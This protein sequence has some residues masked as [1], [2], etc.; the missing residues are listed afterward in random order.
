M[1]HKYIFVA[2]KPGMSEPDFFRYWKEVHAER[3]GKK[4]KQARGYVIDSRIPFG[5]EP[6]EPLFSGAAEVWLDSEADAMEFIQSREY[7]D[8]SRL[9][10]PNFLA[11]W[12]MTVVDTEPHQIVGTPPERDAGWVKLLVLGKRNWSLSVDEFRRQ[13]LDV[14]APLVAALPG[15]KSYPVGLVPDSW[16]GVGEPLLDSVSQLYFEDT[17]ALQQALASPQFRE[18]VQPSVAR[19][20]ESKHVHTL[21]TDEYW[22]TPPP[23]RPIGPLSPNPG[24]TPANGVDPLGAKWTAG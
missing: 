15:L 9:D 23:G 14:H 4:I 18:K 13:I 19:L 21:V 7:I 6:A 17:C 2:P 1:I 5:P 11:F 8:G 24:G 20:L 12:R 16:Y 3:Y 10:E 22:V